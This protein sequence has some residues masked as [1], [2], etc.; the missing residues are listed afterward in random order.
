MNIIG[1]SAATYPSI[2][3]EPSSI[4]NSALTPGENITVS[5]KTNYTGNDVWSYQFSLF[6]NPA[7]LEGVQAELANGDIITFAVSPCAIFV[8][9]EFNNNTGELSLTYAYFFY[10]RD[11][12]GLWPAPVASGPGTLANVTFTVVGKGASNITLGP[13]TKLLGF[14]DVQLGADDKYYGWG[15]VY[16]IIHAEYHPDH[17][18]HGYFRN[19]P[20]G[21]VTH[22]IAVTSVT[23][24][25]TSVVLGGLVD[26]TVV[27][28]NQGTVSEDIT[29][30]VYYRHESGGEEWLIQ[31]KIVAN[32]AA[33]ANT[34]LTF[35]WDTTDAVGMPANFVIKAEAEPVS[36]ETDTGDNTLLSEEMVTVRAEPE[37]PI[38]LE[39]IIGIVVAVAAVVGVVTFALRRGKK[40]IPE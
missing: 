3:I 17:I 9:G 23:P 37:Q 6:F 8:P 33:G 28:E 27:V 40:P 21:E 12:P 15:D 5:I 38:P 36:G 20:E 13:D 1:V 26:I 18:Q 25:P 22:D 31:T 35:T 16:T 11:V 39:L 24:S 29:V 4:E 14:T 30:N 7:V 32:L 2:Y 19:I 10:Q 34:T